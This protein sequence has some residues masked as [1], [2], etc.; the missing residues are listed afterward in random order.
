MSESP[1]PIIFNTRF[2]HSTVSTIVHER[3]LSKDDGKYIS[4]TNREDYL[5]YK[6]SNPHSTIIT[7]SNVN[8]NYPKK[9]HRSSRKSS[10]RKRK[11]DGKS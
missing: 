5:N 6:S 2:N 3:N 9:S 4:I 10:G 7:D 8:P 11:N 1:K